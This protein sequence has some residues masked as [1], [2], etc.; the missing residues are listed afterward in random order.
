[1][2]V[3]ITLL[4]V[5]LFSISL[6]AQPY[7]VGKRTVSFTDASRSNRVIQT[8]INYPA[9]VAGSNT[10]LAGG[11]ASFPVIVFGHGFLIG[12]G[13]YQW[14]ADSLV[15]YGYIVALPATEG[16]V[17]PSHGQ[18]G[19]DLS[20]L[21][22]YITSLND[23]SSSFLYQRVIKK[24]AVG[25]HSMGG[26]SS[27]LAAAQNNSAIS[28]LFNFAAAETNPSATTAALSVTKP[29]LIFSGSNDCIAA[30]AV[31]QAM[32]NNIASCKFYINITNAL[33]CQFAGNNG[34]CATGQVFSGCN[35]SSINTP[36]VFNKV[37]TMLLPFLDYYL[38]GICLRGNDFDNAY[39]T[40]T[41]VTKTRS[42]P[43]LPSCGILPVTLVSFRGV[44]NNGK[45]E[46][47]WRSAAEISLRSYTL[48]RSQDGISFVQFNTILPKASAGQGANYAATDA[49]P[50][51]GTS[52]YRLR[53]TDN[54]GTI[55]YSDVV[56]LSSPQKTF[57]ITALYPNPVMDIL[58]LQV[59]ADRRQQITFTMLDVTGRPVSIQKESFNSG[60]VNASL[61]LTKLSSGTYIM[62][63][64]GDGSS[65]VSGS[66]RVIK[67]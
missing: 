46:L 32:Y 29:S 43:A 24:A 2:K 55:K 16:G 19:S 8:D 5:L 67:K 10:P 56:K 47:S 50:F 51:S 9:T 13:S 27:F 18:F 60:I 41:G 36:I 31:Q 3:F 45:A 30:P 7:P 37:Q 40:I 35:S 62:Q 25:G 17:L 6:S 4:A 64:K 48:E 44:M 63:Y 58:T 42:C 66:F 65:Y 59:Q 33:H 38:K 23:S 1:M 21:C 34:I 52:F 53:I 57:T 39:N 49:Y 12:T 14:L 20:F 26:G 28:V 22:S 54:D 11:T 61:N 15:K